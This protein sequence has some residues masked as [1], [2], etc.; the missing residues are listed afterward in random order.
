MQVNMY[1]YSSTV[2]NCP[3]STCTESGCAIPLASA[4]VHLTARSIGRS[5]PAAPSRQDARRTAYNSDSA[6]RFEPLGAGL[7]TATVT[8]APT[9]RRARTRAAYT[10]ARQRAPSSPRR[11]NVCTRKTLRPPATDGGSHQPTRRAGEAA[12]AN[13]G[14]TRRRR[15]TAE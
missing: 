14:D 6:G 12:S 10:R 5:R 1:M 2:Q 7:H 3:I 9:R 4:V 11:T 13:Q 15:V 8:H